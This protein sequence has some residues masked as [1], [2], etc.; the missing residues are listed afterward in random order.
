MA[1]RSWGGLEKVFVDL[2]NSLSDKQ[3]LHVIVFANSYV[4][5]YFNKRVTLHLLR[6][7]PTRFNP[8]LYFELKKTIHAIAPDIIHTHGAK[9]SELI[10]RLGVQTSH[11]ATK[12]STSN[13]K[14]FNKISH[15]T[16]VSK[17]TKSTIKNNN[18]Q[19]VY[20]GIKPKPLELK[21]YDF[22][23]TFHMVAVGRLDKIKGFDILIEE[24]SKL[25]FDFRLEIIGDGP[26]RESLERLIDS[27]GMQAK[28]EIVGFQLDVPQR[29]QKV[30]LVVI[31]SHS[32]GFG[33][34]ILE[35][36]HYAKMLVS[37]PV[38][39]ASEI[40]PH[41]FLTTHDTLATK[42]KSIYENLSYFH[43][44]FRDFA[45]RHKDDFLLDTVSEKYLSYY[46]HTL[47]KKGFYA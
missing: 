8:A 22:N 27:L 24:C 3:E 20:N 26:Q 16:A 23:A 7:N 5:D 10:Y 46:H 4:K 30:D 21:Q 39:I 19:V 43:A 13:G 14:I 12:H 1:S 42:I 47:A 38:G 33:L 40:L 17:Q 29:M 32:E 18:V 15:V 36:M 35:A 34:I 2:C 25:D 37:T 9:A 31:S 44:Q 41:D 11:I 6:A 28:I 45:N